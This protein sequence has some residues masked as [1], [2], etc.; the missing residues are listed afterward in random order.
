[1]TEPYEDGK[2]AYG[3]NLPACANPY[4]MFSQSSSHEE[5]ERGWNAASAQHEAQDNAS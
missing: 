3:Y 2:R 4:N 1:M 5:W